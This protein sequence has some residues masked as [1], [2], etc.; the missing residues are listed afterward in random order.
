VFLLKG[1]VSKMLLTKRKLQLVNKI[2]S[3]NTISNVSCNKCFLENRD[4]YVMPNSRLKC[5]KCT[6]VRRLCVNMS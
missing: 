1:R 6:Q 2:L 4:C 3:A 5:A